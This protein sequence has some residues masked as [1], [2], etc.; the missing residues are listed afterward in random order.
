MARDIVTHRPGIVNDA[1][2]VRAIDAPGPGGANRLY[3]IRD[4]DEGNALLLMF[5]NGPPQE[6][7]NGNVTNEAL[8]AIVADRLQGFEAGPYPSKYNRRA[9]EG[10]QHALYNLHQRTLDRQHRQVEGQ[11]TP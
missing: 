3:E 1:L 4:V 10:V 11:P 2:T 8:L 5:Q 7:I 9:L 6:G